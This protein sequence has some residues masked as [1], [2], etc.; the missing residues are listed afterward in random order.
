MTEM[1]ETMFLSH[2]VAGS[3]VEGQ[4]ALYQDNPADPGDLRVA[5]PEAD[6]AL[7][8]EAVAAARTAVGA[9]RARGI[10][11][12]ADAL[13]AI[14]RA[15][16]TEVERL[17]VLIARE[18]G[19]ILPDAR[20]EVMRAARIFDF[21]AGEI[22][23]NVGERF[24]ST[25]PGVTVEVDHAPVGVVGLITPWNFPIAIPAWKIAPALAFGNGVVWKPSELSSAVAAA[26]MD[27]VAGSAL[28]PG[29]V[30]MVLGGGG[31]GAALSASDRIDALSFT[32]S[33][34]T[35][36]RIRLTAAANNVRVQAEMGGVNGLIVRADADL[37]NAVDCIVNGA[38]FA[39]GQRCTAT[40]RII[41]EDAIADELSE[42][43]AARLA[44]LSIG[45]PRAAGV[46]VGPLVSLAQKQRIAA[47]VR[48]VEATGLRA[49]RT[50][51]ADEMPHAF[52]PPTLFFDAPADSPLGQEE[53]FGP[54]AGLFRVPDFE[55][56]LALLNGNRFGLSAG[57]CTRSL[58]HAE[59]FKA[60]ASAGML[61]V[62]QPTA[63]VDYHAPFG[64]RGASS[65]GTREQGRAAREFYTATVTSYQLPL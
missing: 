35:G 19:K 17:A 51:G 49:V 40:S 48:A 43:L 2:H 54:V 38:F 10:E 42:R 37:G 15:L 21:F 20:G 41:A 32:G 62:N 52:Y 27:I 31:A 65:Q 44:G 29:A 45:D 59:A 50:G 36:R 13:A 11:A 12:R 1:T 25:R 60:R 26:L 9:M 23:R 57:I 8:D 3:A 39:A 34:A 6:S 46:M 24:A 61:M 4:P 18:T 53:I 28:P 5:L 7:I 56:A 16:V 33:E 30:N 58:A 55:A 22:L 14:A 64:G 47:Q 63:G